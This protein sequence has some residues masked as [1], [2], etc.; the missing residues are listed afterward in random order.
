MRH[1]ACGCD[2][3]PHRLIRVTL[4]CA[5]L[6]LTTAIGL[7]TG[8]LVGSADAAARVADTTCSTSQE[9]DS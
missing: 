5:A 2:R 9:A 4:C 8:T 7:R 6:V 3:R 1:R